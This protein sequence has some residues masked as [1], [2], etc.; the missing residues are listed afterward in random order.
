MQCGPLLGPKIVSAFFVPEYARLF[1]FYE[2]RNIL[3]NFHSCGDVESLLD[4]FIQLGVDVLNPIQA[5]AND[6]AKIRS[7]TQGRM[8]LQG[9]VSSATV[10]DGPVERITAEVRERI[11]Q[12]GQY[13]GYF[14]C[15]D[16]DMPFPPSHFAAL[17]T[18]VKVYGEFPLHPPD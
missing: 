4:T 1:R 14:C 13:G 9:G 6:L 3:I 10:M 15:Q 8:A 5:T 7:R 18:A 11:W 12:L 2:E 16:Q 17:Q